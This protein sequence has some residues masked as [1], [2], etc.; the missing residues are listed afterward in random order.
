MNKL[1]L[2]SILLF[3]FCLPFMAIQADED[4]IVRRVYAHLLIKDNQAAYN[5]VVAG[6]KEYP[7]SKRLHEYHL[8][9]L[10]SSGDNHALTNAWEQ[11]SQVDPEAIKNRAILETYAWGS[12]EKGYVAE[13]AITRL[14]AMLAGFFSQ[15]AKGIAILEAGMRDNNAIIRALAV[16]LACEAHDDRLRDSVIRLYQEERAWNVRLEVI[17]AIGSMRIL[18]LAKPLE[19]LINQESVPAE[20]KAAALAS[21]VEIYETVERNEVVKFAKSN[22][23]GMRLLACEMIY[24]LDLE[25][26]VDLLVLLANDQVAEVRMAAIEAMGL[27]PRKCTLT[28]APEIARQHI[29]DN[30]PRV[31]I[32]AAWLLTLHVPSEGHCALEKW[33]NHDKKDYR[34]LA[35]GAVVAS[36]KYGVDLAVKY[37]QQT[38]DPYIRMNMAHALIS[39]RTHTEKAAEAIYNELMNNR[40]RWMWQEIGIFRML[41]LSNVKLKEETPQY[42]E[43]TN[44]LVRLELLQV[45]AFL[46]HPRAK[47]AMK[48]F[49]KGRTFGITGITVALLLTQGDE[50][51]LD[52]IRDL[53]HDPDPQIRMQATL[54]L[55]LWGHDEG[56]IKH[57]E[58]GYASSDRETREKIIEGLGR[59]GSE[60]SIPFLVS[61][62]SEPS[63]CLRIIAASSLLQCLY[64]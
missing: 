21:L 25:R 13:T 28:I 49:L 64:H 2:T 43:V 26:D 34:M 4:Q 7:H 52:L 61:R 47:D 38:K 53:T 17:K 12:I 35:C 24:Q 40:D 1:H 59:I 55:A 37:F 54:I 30:D 46:H 18:E 31:S 42:P 29:N 62:L 23:A 19:T 9:V 44:Q 16:K 58:E 57:L 60:L 14:M 6:L 45:L 27:M 63:H 3:F 15:S 50:D 20:Q 41:A 8:K 48:E 51:A 11:Y 32:A 56:V 10:S 36:G 39:Q 33:L 22:R 5:E